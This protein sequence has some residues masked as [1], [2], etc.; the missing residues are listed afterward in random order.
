VLVEF[1]SDEQ[2]A[3][4]GRFLGEPA[5]EQLE[6]FFWLDDRSS[7]RLFLIAL[8]AREPGS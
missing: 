7:A 5:R 8:M 3:A 4:Y 6:R 2:A 1:P